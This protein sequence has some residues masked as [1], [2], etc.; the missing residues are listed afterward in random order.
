M[1]SSTWNTRVA[2]FELAGNFAT[3]VGGI[4]FWLWVIVR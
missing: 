1:K 2:A 4:Y 3:F